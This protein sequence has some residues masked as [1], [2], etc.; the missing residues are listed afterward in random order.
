MARLIDSG[1]AE[2]KRILKGTVVIAEVDPAGPSDQYW[3]ELVR[4]C[5]ET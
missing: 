4:H 1:L 3:G 2:T 5:L